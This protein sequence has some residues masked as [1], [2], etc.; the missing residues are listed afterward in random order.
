MNLTFQRISAIALTFGMSAGLISCSESKVSQCNKMTAVA[1]RAVEVGQTFSQ[2]AKASSDSKVLLEM[3]SQIDQ[4][5]KD[6]QAIT[7]SDEKL[8]GFQTRFVTLYKTTHQGLQNVA[9]A[10]AKKELPKAKQVLTS[11]ESDKN[12][13]TTLVNEFN[14]YCSGVSI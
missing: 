6:M 4:L 14:N 7:L 5:T 10:I 11:L 12:Q 1:N 8:Q 9:T 2:K 13:E 3:A